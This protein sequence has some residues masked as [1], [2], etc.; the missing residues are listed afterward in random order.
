MKNNGREDAGDAAP[1]LAR[2][3]VPAG[4]AFNEARYDTYL[5]SPGEGGG[6]VIRPPRP[7]PTFSYMPLIPVF[8]GGTK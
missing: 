3:R 2:H 1:G 7:S 8:A 5:T 4:P 6:T